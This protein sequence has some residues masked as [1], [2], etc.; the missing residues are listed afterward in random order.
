MKTQSLWMALVL[1]GLMSCELLQE[2]D[3]Q[4]DVS[5]NP[6]SSSEI[7]SFSSQGED[8]NSS[9]SKESSSADVVDSLSSE[10]QEKQ[11]SDDVEMSSEPQI[12]SSSSD[13]VVD[14]LAICIDNLGTIEFQYEN[15]DTAFVITSYE[16]IVKDFTGKVKVANDSGSINLDLKAYQ[17]SY[18]KDLHKLSL[19]S[20]IDMEMTINVELDRNSEVTTEEFQIPIQR[21]EICGT[22]CGVSND[23]VTLT[24]NKIDPPDDEEL[25]KVLNQ[26]EDF[27]K[28]IQEDVAFK[29]DYSRSC[30]CPP[31]YTGPYSVV[32][33]QDSVVSYEYIGPVLADLRDVWLDEKELTIDAM[34][35]VLIKA[36]KGDVADLQYK[37]HSEYPIPILISIDQIAD[38]IDDEVSYSIQNFS[39]ED[40]VVSSDLDRVLEKY[41]DFKV[42]ISNEVTFKYEYARSCFCPPEYTGPYAVVSIQDSVVSYEYIGSLFVDLDA[43]KLDEKELR[44]DTLFQI[45]INALK[46]DVASLKYEFHEQY[47]IPTL[48][49]IDYIAGVADDE[50]YYSVENFIVE[51]N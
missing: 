22:I 50:M 19:S 4:N 3:N 11:S 2:E 26:Y 16:I 17:N 20:F 13:W 18:I 43:V 40:S 44:I 5:G 21:S 9:E 28:W 33:V 35:Q 25:E 8:N 38:A 15:G 27:K 47:P 37:F 36:L 32:S 39:V 24:I 1:F 14:C 29:Y 51:G 7:I 30:F 23:K 46:E 49:D 42:L 31:E 48:I 34:F 45:L 41:E 10:G 12:W 6:S